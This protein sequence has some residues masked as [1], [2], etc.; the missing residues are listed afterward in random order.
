MAELTKSE[1]EA[2]EAR[3]AEHSLQDDDVILTTANTMPERLGVKGAELDTAG[4]A[5]HGATYAYTRKQV[6]QALE[7]WSGGGRASRGRPPRAGDTRTARTQGRAAA[8]APPE[9]KTPAEVE[10]GERRDTSADTPR[11]E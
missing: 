1:L 7:A 6:N 2:A 9:G 3:A 5:A 8:D 4:S 11:P 10:Q